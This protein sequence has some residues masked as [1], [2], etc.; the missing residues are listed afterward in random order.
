MPFILFRYLSR[1]YQEFKKRVRIAVDNA[2][3]NAFRGSMMYLVMITLVWIAIF[4][5]AVFYYAYVPAL[6]FVRPVHLQIP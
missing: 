2:L 3:E 5:Y 6:S 1:K 4:L